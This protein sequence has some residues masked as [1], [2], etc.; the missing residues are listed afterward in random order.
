MRWAQ[1]LTRGALIGQNP[2][3]GQM[4]NRMIETAA[5]RWLEQQR[6]DPE[7]VGAPQGNI[8][9]FMRDAFGAGRF[10]PQSPTF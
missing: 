10:N 3:S 6:L 1:N 4:I 9:S 5:D 8:Y 7:K 2:E